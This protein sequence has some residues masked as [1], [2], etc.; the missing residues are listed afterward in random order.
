MVFLAVNHGDS[1]EVI[2]R[3]WEGSGF[4][5]GWSQQISGNVSRAFGVE[6]YPSNFVIDA[7]GKVVYGS[8]G[9]DEVAI[10]R[11]LAAAAGE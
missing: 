3:Y 5:L 2:Q 11:A 1:R 9:Y 8:V 4:T 6:T 10:R 7:S